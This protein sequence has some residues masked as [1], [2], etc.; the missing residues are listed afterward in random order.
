GPDRRGERVPAV[1]MRGIGI[2]DGDQVRAGQVRT[3]HPVPEDHRVLGGQRVLH[4][5][6]RVDAVPAGRRSGCAHRLPPP[7]PPPPPPPPPPGVALSWPGG[8]APPPPL[9]P[10]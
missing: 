2:L 5:L 1:P 6:D 4:R 7:L 9:R 3:G 10:P 8:A